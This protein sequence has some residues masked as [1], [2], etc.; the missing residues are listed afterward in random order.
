M[1]W[2]EVDRRVPPDTQSR[3]RRRPQDRPSAAEQRLRIVESSA[4][5]LA[6]ALDDL[7][8]AITNP[9]T[10]DERHDA[11][12]RRLSCALVWFGSMYDRVRDVGKKAWPAL[13]DQEQPKWDRA[14]GRLARDPLTK[15]CCELRNVV[16]HQSP[17]W[18]NARDSTVDGV[19]F[20]I[21][22]SFLVGLH[23]DSLNTA[24][25]ERVGENLPV[26]E[27]AD[28]LRQDALEIARELTAILQ[29]AA[30]SLPT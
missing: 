15:V 1:D 25:G 28:F 20:Y 22:P 23:R 10:L 7:H 17:F 12:D 9:G 24:L 18:V 14:I 6:D 29:A 5:L 21:D 13:P 2:N 8:D 19:S 4:A 16:V 3:W 27:L 26:Q 30:E 11:V